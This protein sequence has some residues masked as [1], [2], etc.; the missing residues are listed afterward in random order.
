MKIQLIRQ[1]VIAEIQGVATAAGCQLV[2]SCDLADAAENA[3]FATPGERIGLFCTTPMVALSR[4]IGRKRAL[5]MLLTGEMI[6]AATAAEWGLIN[7]AV[8]ASALPAETRRLA[9]CIAGASP[10]TVGI[11]KQAWYAQVDLAQHEAYAY[12]K[13]VMSLNALTADAQEGIAAFLQ[14]RQASWS[15][16]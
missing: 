14:K 11:G 5:E 15:G 3:S 16:K 6:S 8:R 4:A 13:Q 7:R 12:A 1:P 10:L 2:A 9:N